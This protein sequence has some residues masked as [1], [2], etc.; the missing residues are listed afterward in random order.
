MPGEVTYTRSEADYVEAQRDWWR[1]AAFKPGWWVRCLT[2]SA[3]FFAGSALFFGWNAPT[4]SSMV[5]Y[6]VGG[7]A[8]F[9][10]I[11][12]LCLVLGYFLMPRRSLKLFRQTPNRDR[13]ITFRWSEAGIEEE[14]ANGTARYSWSD[15]Y[16]WRDG[17]SAVLLYRND[18][19][20]HF[21]PHRVLAGGQLDE[22][23]GLLERHC[24]SQR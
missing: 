5:I 20:F 21:L 8:Y 22:I 23:R 11:W 9:W 19:L 15:F 17:R 2:A 24:P 12:A 7:A 1:G 6:G 3:V 13:P 4:I 18:N 14:A 16:R 10:L